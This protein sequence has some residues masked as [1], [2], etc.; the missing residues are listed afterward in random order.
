M[1]QV[2]IFLAKFKKVTAEAYYVASSVKED[3]YERYVY[4]YDPETP[5]RI[6]DEVMVFRE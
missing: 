1:M 3:L 6:I 5:T 2:N 4:L